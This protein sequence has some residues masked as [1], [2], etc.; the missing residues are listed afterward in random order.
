MVSLLVV[1][2]KNGDTG[3]LLDSSDTGDDSV[4]LGELLGTD[5]EGDGRHNG[6]VDRD[7]TDQENQ[8][9]SETLTVREPEA[10]VQ[11]EDLADDEDTNGDETEGTNLGENLL[12]VTGGLVVL[13]DERGG[14]TEEGAGTS[15]DKTPSASPR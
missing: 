15:R 10:G 6:H 7:T 12:Q 9:V 5:G 3:Q 4:L 11:D 2:V 8:D 13:T 14:T 1:S